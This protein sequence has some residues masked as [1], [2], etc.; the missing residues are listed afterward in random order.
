MYGLHVDCY[1]MTQMV[2]LT[3]GGLL[4]LVRQWGMSGSEGWKTFVYQPQ[5]V[6]RASSRG[7]NT[8]L[9][10]RERRFCPWNILM[11]LCVYPYRL[12]INEHCFLMIEWINSAV[13]KSNGKKPSA[14]YCPT[15]GLLRRYGLAIELERQIW[16]V[17]MTHEIKDLYC[18]VHAY[19]AL[20]VN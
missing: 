12:A 6:S 3:V 14:H 10:D 7:S 5:K 18:S 17:G 2:I 19:R 11:L 15:T 20:H 9:R 4:I 1:G 8:G 16:D 13:T